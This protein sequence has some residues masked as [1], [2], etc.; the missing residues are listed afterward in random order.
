M[1]LVGQGCHSLGR[2][3]VDSDGGDDDGVDGDVDVRQALNQSIIL[4]NR[5]RILQ[6]SAVSDVEFGLP[7]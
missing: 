1:V 3:V 4:N 2:H 7:E 6:I 5:L